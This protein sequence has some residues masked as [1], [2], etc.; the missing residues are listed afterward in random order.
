M[1][2]TKYYVI[3]SGEYSETGVVGITTDL[4][5]A[6]AF[7]KVSNAE[8]GYE[9]FWIYDTDGT[10]FITDANFIQRATN[11]ITKFVYRFEAEIIGGAKRWSIYDKYGK[12]YQTTEE[13]TDT[14]TK[15]IMDE[16]NAYGATFHVYTDK[17]E[18]AD[19]I[20]YDFLAKKNAEE[21]G[22]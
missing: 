10:E 1:N 20:A 2:D 7:C 14:G 17:Q 9:H 4:E 13:T 12:C 19:K 21:I 11:V 3:M 5:L 15:F 22:L 6:E 8:W 18:I 16:N